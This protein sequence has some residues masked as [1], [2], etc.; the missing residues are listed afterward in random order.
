MERDEARRRGQI[1]TLVA[2]VTLL[3]VLCALMVVLTGSQGR[4]AFDTAR[5]VWAGEAGATWR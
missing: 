3:C 4:V 1:A 2:L 5:L